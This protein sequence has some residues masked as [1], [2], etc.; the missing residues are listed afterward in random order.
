MNASFR[1]IVRPLAALAAA[2][3]AFGF[4]AG[5][6]AAP[7]PPRPTPDVPDKLDLKIA[8]TYALEHNY[9]IRQARERIREQEGVILEVKSRALPNASL[10]SFYGKT[11]EELGSDRGPGAGSD[12]NWEI[13]L[14]VRQLLY[15]GGSVR[16]ALDAQKAL[17]ESVLLDLKGTINDALLEVRTRF[18]GVLLGREQIKVQEANVQLLREQLQIARNRFEAGSSSNFEVLRA[19]V[20][21]ANAQPA[22]IRARNALRNA[23]EE[24]RQS[25]GYLNP[26]VESLTKVPDF[27]G[28]L[29]FEPVS[30]DLSQALDSARANR[31]ELKRLGK[32]ED[33]REAGVRNAKS[34]YLPDLA[35]VG[36]YQFRKN[37]FSERFGDSVDG[38]TAGVQSNWAIFDGRATRGRVAQ[39]RSQLEQARLAT[40]EAFLGVEVEVRRAH[41]ALQ[42]AAE[43]AGAAQKVVGQAEEALRLADARY[44]AGT[45]TQLDVLEARVA[46]T[47]SRLNQLQANY[48]HNVATAALRK[49]MGQG[50]PMVFL[51]LAGPRSD[52]F[53]VSSSELD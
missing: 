21:V 51:P 26:R 38:W 34:G 25:L 32:I 16:S 42:E 52:Q 4:A 20:A 47:E 36:G 6:Q 40:S 46:L 43:L 29:E 41:S 3:A 27:V 50:D 2:A 24:L 48:S 37:N 44:S 11:D 13:T 17:R 31:P 14:Q 45:A 53:G 39:A 10:Q 7:P 8:L 12:Q 9:S 5:S 1:L 23:V 30:Y 35:V 18:Y 22:L 33:A 49:A 19:E 28:T 15:S